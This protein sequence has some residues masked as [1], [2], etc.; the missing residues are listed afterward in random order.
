MPSATAAPV[1]TGQLCPRSARLV[2]ALAVGC[3]RH[4]EFSAC[5]PLQGTP[6]AECQR[7]HSKFAARW[8]EFQPRLR[9][10]IAASRPARPSRPRA[11]RP[12]RPARSRYASQEAAAQARRVNRRCGGRRSDCSA[13][14]VG[15]PSAVRR[16][17]GM[18]PPPGLIAG[19]PA[20]YRWS[21][22]APD[23]PLIRPE[24]E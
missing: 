22:A 15:T 18:S 4:G 12:V 20:A 17:R 21:A 3:P 8:G 5:G 16:R 23:A 11:E 10:R 7:L 13:G 2:V 14:H 24:K 19:P 1:Y 9:L 6:G